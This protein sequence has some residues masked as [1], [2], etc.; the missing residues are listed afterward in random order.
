MASESKRHDTA[1][2]VTVLASLASIALAAGIVSR[3]ITHMEFTDRRMEQT[4]NEFRVW[5]TY[6]EDLRNEMIL[7]GLEPPPPPRRGNE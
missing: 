5:Q 1:A 3:A 6:V 4:E 2:L 7:A